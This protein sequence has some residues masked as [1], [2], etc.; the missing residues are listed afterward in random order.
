MTTETQTAVIT[1]HAGMHL[2]IVRTWCS[3]NGVA[4]NEDDVRSTI[5]ARIYDDLDRRFGR[6]DVIVL[7]TNQDGETRV[8]DA[9][10]DYLRFEYLVI[11]DC[12]S[13]WDVWPNGRPRSLSF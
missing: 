10:S 4:Y 11:A 2:E 6:A 12:C 8:E 3:A 7:V 13:V 1:V 9:P 5:A